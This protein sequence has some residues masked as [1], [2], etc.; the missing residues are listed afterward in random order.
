MLTLV[1]TDKLKIS[2]MPFSH[3]D[4]LVILSTRTGLRRRNH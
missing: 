4:S 3:P 2:D 1:E